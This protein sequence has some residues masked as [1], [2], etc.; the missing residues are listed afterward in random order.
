MP[1]KHS[2]KQR[3]SRSLVTKSQGG[4]YSMKSTEQLGDALF[5]QDHGLVFCRLS[6]EKAAEIPIES[7]FA[8]CQLVETGLILT[9]NASIFTLDL[10]AGEIRYSP[11]IR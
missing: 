1:L 9:S 3:T 10:G 7:F 11:E 6:Y 2:R 5:F 4:K 8:R